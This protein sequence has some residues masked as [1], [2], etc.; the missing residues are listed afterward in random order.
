MPAV[1]VKENEPFDIALRRFKRSCEKA[2]VL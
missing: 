1:R 2:G